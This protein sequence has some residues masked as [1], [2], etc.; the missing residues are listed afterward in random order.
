MNV[1]IGSICG[2]GEAKQGSAAG[3]CECDAIEMFGAASQLR[4]PV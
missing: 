3:A 4:K 1:L 2:I